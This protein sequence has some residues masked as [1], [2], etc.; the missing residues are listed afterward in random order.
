MT[1]TVEHLN[2]EG[3][4]RNPAFTQAIAVSGP[5]RVIYVG[6]QDAVDPSGNV[7]G[8]GDIRAQAEQIFHNLR[9]AL[10]AGG[11]SLEHV[12]K[13][14]I[15]VVQGQP[16]MPAFEVFRQQWGERPNPP[17]ISVLYV[18]GLANPEFLAEIDAVAVVPE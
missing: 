11:A 10:A 18:A 4:A 8:Q 6:G 13:W 3:L 16:L 2:P 17:T 12:V 5:H 14:T 7:V 9:T 1:S 15:Y